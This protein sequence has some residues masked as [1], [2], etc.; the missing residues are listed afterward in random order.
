MN[1]VS[2]RALQ[3]SKIKETNGS[4]GT[5]LISCWLVI[6]IATIILTLYHRYRVKKD[7]K[8]DIL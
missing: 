4:I 7:I 6:I 8:N 1:V 3:D 2:K 5:V